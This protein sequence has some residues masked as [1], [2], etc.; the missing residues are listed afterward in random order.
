VLRVEDGHA[1][2]VAVRLGLRGARAAELLDGL[3]EGDLVLP[4]N[5]PVAAGRR[6]R[7]P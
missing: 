6:V 3:D 7:M 1:R 2:R 5:A 4:V